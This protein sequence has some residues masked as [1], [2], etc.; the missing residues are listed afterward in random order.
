VHWDDADL[1]LVEFVAAVARLRKEHPTF[2]RSRFF[3]GRPV[4]RGEGEPLPDIAWLTPEGDAMAPEDWDVPLGRALGVFLNGDGIRG[5][6]ARGERVVD[7]NFLVLFNAN[8]DPVEFTLPAD[9]YS[10]QWEVVIDTAGHAVSTDPVAA[11]AT[12][13]A[14]SRSTLVLRAHVETAP[15][16]DSAVAASLQVLTNSNVGTAGFQTPEAE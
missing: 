2:R 12:I 7:R 14:Q 11:G 9:E 8:G 16:F 1:S 13:T 4:R 3:D 15:E 10:P 6:D 5:R